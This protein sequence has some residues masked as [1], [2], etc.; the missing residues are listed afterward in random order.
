MWG[1]LR[2][3]PNVVL[4][5]VER[6]SWMD[7]AL[8]QDVRAIIRVPE[9]FGEN[10]SKGL[11]G[12]IELYVVVRSLGMSESGV[13]SA[14]NEALSRLSSALSAAIIS[15]HAPSLN[16]T[17]V[18]S[19]L[20]V[21]AK[22]VFKGE[23]VNTPPERFVFSVTAQ[24]FMMPI[25]ML[26]IMVLASQT[27]VTSIA[28]EK[29]EKT[30]ETLLTLP[31]KRVT[32]LWGKLVGSTIVAAFAVLAYMAGFSYY[33]VASLS[34]QEGGLSVASLR[35]PPEGYLV[36][37]TSLFLSLLSLLAL[38][39][40]LGAYTQDVRSAQSLLG[41]IFIPILVPAFVLMY[42][43]VSTLPVGL[44]ML[45][46]AIPFSHPMIAAKAVL[47]GDYLIPLLGISYN[48]AFTVLVLFIA[49]KF[50]SSERVV[51]ARITLK[52]SAKVT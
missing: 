29:E 33:M 28:I 12:E 7:D 50:F 8:A 16:A 23:V 44:Q 30:L 6:A 41:L 24:S 1:F 52:K 17:N 18:L 31:V 40:L 20:I 13:Q 9:G 51:T 27:A 48:A 47:V 3:M 38:S 15:A 25:M 49:A 37:A 35:T 36:L 14:L 5:N 2:R 19:P 11:R 32:V 26:I 45:L 42:A 22:T 39:L 46:Y 4:V 43:D 21:E 34:A 10:L